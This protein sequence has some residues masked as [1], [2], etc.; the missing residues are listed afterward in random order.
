MNAKLTQVAVTTF[1]VCVVFYAL[2]HFAPTVRNQ[3]TGGTAVT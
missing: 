1:A 3:I 2:G